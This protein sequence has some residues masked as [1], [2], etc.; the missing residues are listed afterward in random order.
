MSDYGI[1]ER[2]GLDV[3][4]P[5]PRWWWRL[6]KWL[7]V[8]LAMMVMLAALGAAGVAYAT[9]DYSAKYRG[10]LLPGTVVAGIDV[11]GMRPRRA[12]AAVRAKIDPRLERRINVRYRDRRWTL[13][14]RSLG[15][16]SNAA[17]VVRAAV[18]A[19]SRATFLDKARMRVLG[20]NL[21][22]NRPVSFTYPR[23]GVRGFVDGVAAKLNLEPLDASLE[24]S[25]GWVEITPDRNGRKVQEA[26]SE[27]AL[28]RALHNGSPKVSL[29]VQVLR[30]EV[31]TESYDKVL[32]VR[33]GENRLYLYEN[34]EIA[35]S[36]PVATG[37]PEYMTPTG[38][39]EIV[40]KRYLPTWINPAPTTWGADL[41]PEIPPGP[42]NPLGLR[43]LNW[44][45]PAI[46]F[47][48]T[49]ATYSLG[50][51]ASHGCVRLSNT[52]VI[53]LYDLVDVGT[54]VVSLVAGSLKPLYTSSLDPTPVADDN[55]RGRKKSSK[56]SKKGG[57]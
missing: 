7:A 26:K 14:P 40:E 41:P 12:L 49:E 17:G 42:S 30:P 29:P 45:A 28:M 6:S 31:T 50:Y 10:R 46:R 57:N 24:Y 55:A 13:T 16:R 37:Q 53:Q 18:N 43:A 1:S 5:A 15:A 38:M 39:Y 36:W 11:S 27:A 8:A 33:I 35:H 56:D 48:G 52:D 32:L 25:S 19:S 23:G 22:F 44:S 47:H 34:G 3:V 9:Y 51:N 2:A 4:A 54:P 21:N 20:E